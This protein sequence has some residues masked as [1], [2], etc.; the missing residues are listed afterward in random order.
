MRRT[1]GRKGKY[2]RTGQQNTAGYQIA[3]FEP[4]GIF[5]RA[6]GI[7][8]DQS[9]DP[10]DQLLQAQGDSGDYAGVSF[11]PF[12]YLPSQDDIY[13]SPSQIRKF[14]LRT[15]D[16]V[17]GRYALP[18]TMS[19]FC[20]LKVEV[21]GSPPEESIKRIHFDALTPLYPTEKLT[22]ETDSR[23]LSTRIIIL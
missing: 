1:T 22:L 18:R 16:H 5:K 20:L 13:V 6:K 11:R 17:T 10:F 23:E 2:L 8:R 3:G 15:G 7:C 19:A 14:E 21:N 12:G 9:L 4:G